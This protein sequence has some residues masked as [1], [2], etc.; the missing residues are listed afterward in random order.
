[1]SPIPFLVISKV[2]PEVM[3]VFRN[4]PSVGLL[5]TFTT[6][7]RACCHYLQCARSCGKQVFPQLVRIS[8]WLHCVSSQNQHSSEV[9]SVLV[10]KQQLRHV[11]SHL[12]LLY[13]TIPL[14]VSHVYRLQGPRN[15]SL[16]ISCIE[17]IY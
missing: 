6:L 7:L 2:T 16:R 8:A 1:M 14:C 10:A 12:F 13:I 17:Y 9:G 4:A 11:R 3:A 5:E 15:T